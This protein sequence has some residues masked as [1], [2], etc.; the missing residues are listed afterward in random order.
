[1]DTG[2][3]NIGGSA[4]AYALAR[5][6]H[7]PFATPP[8]VVWLPATLV[9]LAMLLPLV[10]LFVRSAGATHEARDLL[11]RLRTLLILTR[12]VVLVVMVDGIRD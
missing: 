4:G 1:M 9:G 2:N 11:F 6:P 7:L 10:Y 8:V 3:W 12:S 5:R